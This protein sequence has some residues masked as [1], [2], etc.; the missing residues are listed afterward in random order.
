MLF[1]LVI[2][3]KSTMLLLTVIV[4][5]RLLFLQFNLSGGNQKY[6]IN[7]RSTCPKANN[8]KYNGNKNK[9]LT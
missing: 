8:G 7:K 4:K 9:K 3:E 6:E 2:I 5:N 1:M